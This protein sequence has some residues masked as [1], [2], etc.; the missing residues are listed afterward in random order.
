MINCINILEQT[1]KGIITAGNRKSFWCDSRPWLCVSCVRFR[2]WIK[3]GKTPSFILLQTNKGK[4]V[5][6]EN[7]IQVKIVPMEK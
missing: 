6:H 3:S 4:Y 5:H 1:L 7:N 2:H